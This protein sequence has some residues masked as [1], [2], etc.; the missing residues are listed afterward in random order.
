MH[1]SAAAALLLAALALRAGASA[2]APLLRS[3]LAAPPESIRREALAAVDRACDAIREGLDRDGAVRDPAGESPQ[4]GGGAL[5]PAAALA[6]PAAPDPLLAAALA[7]CADTL[8]R[9]WD[10][11]RTRDAAYLLLGAAWARL[12]PPAGL[13]DRLAKTDLSAL[14]VADRA[15]A[16]VALDSFG[17]DTAAGW[18]ALARRAAPAAPALSD[19]A[20]AA[21]ARAARSRRLGGDG[22]SP[23]VLAHVRWL[24][25]RL[26]LVYGGE[27]DPATPLDPA[28]ALLCTVLASSLPR[29]ALAADPGLFPWDWRNHMAN[30][31]VVSQTLDPGTFNPGWDGGASGAPRALATTQAVLA[32]RL[33]AQ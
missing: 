20:A 28:A 3:D 16:L 32:L 27:A 19:V 33:L 31:L 11:G 15:L 12:E 9:P 18:D 2:P 24:A 30:R 10:A 29:H 1:R 23:D 6:D 22:A 26:H 17:A 4:D 25:A 7:R 13:V 8:A 21:L 14:G 5:F